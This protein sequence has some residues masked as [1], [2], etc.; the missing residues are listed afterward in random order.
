VEEL[1]LDVELMDRPVLGKGKGDDGSNGDKL[2]DV[3]KV[4]S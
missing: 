4:S 1:I 3:L 2:D